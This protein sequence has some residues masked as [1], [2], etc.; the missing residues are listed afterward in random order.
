M[1]WCQWLIGLVFFPRQGD[2]LHYNSGPDRLGFGLLSPHL[3]PHGLSPCPPLTHAGRGPQEPGLA[4]LTP[5]PGLAPTW[6]LTWAVLELGAVGQVRGGRVEESTWPG[7]ER[8]ICV[9]P[10]PS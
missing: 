7:T 2:K 4:D 1:P 8:R 3:S 9:R 10:T 5:A 6:S